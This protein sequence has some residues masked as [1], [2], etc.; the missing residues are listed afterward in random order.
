MKVLDSFILL[1]SQ[2]N[3]HEINCKLTLSLNLCLFDMGYHKFCCG[4]EHFKRGLKVSHHFVTLGIHNSDWAMLYSKITDVMV[5]YTRKLVQNM[6][7]SDSVLRLNKTCGIHLR[8]VWD[9]IGIY[10]NFFCY[11]KNHNCRIEPEVLKCIEH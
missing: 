6:F 2:L 10:S 4:I 3:W 7:H 11:G 5:S 9:S 1:N 8:W